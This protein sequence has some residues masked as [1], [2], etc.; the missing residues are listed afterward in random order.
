MRVHLRAS[1]GAVT[2]VR[3]CVCVNVALPVFR[4]VCV[5]LSVCI[6]PYTC[7]S[8]HT[9]NTQGGEC[10]FPLCPTVCCSFQVFSRACNRVGPLHETLTTM[11]N[12]FKIS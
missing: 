4:C 1:F 5:H 7:G 11:T 9:S 2:Q 8:L 6:H 10:V 12:S 3:L